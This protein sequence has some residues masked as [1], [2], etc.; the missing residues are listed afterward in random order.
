[1]AVFGSI[2]GFTLGAAA[3]PPQGEKVL[4]GPHPTLLQATIKAESV[5][6]NR[7]VEWRRRVRPLHDTGRAGKQSDATM[8]NI[9]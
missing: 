8:L 4:T 9:E 5:P 2:D 3:S 7:M 1:M 6:S